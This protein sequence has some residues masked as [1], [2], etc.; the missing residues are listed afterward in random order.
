MALQVV[1]YL[2]PFMNW[3]CNQIAIRYVCVA[4]TCHRK[5]TTVQNDTIQQ[6]GIGSASNVSQAMLLDMMCGTQRQM[7]T[8]LPSFSEKDSLHCPHNECCH[9]EG[10][11]NPGSI[12]GPATCDKHSISELTET[13]TK[14]LGC[15]P[16]L[17][18]I[19]ATQ[20]KLLLCW[21]KE[22]R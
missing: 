13:N 4:R 17:S 2:L 20:S 22:V 7:L 19:M 11:V 15:H 21:N 18:F 3:L 12:I 5:Y 9:T 10:A 6:N 8:V 1:R 16:G 14:T